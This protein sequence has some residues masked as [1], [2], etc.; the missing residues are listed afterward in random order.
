MNASGHKEFIA[1]V[2]GPS[3]TNTN[4]GVL[5]D[6]VDFACMSGAR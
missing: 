5:D 3:K 1:P 6:N 2:I 4:E